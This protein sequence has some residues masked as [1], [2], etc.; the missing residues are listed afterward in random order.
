M[1]RGKASSLVAEGAIPRRSDFAQATAIAERLL[2]GRLGLKLAGLSLEPGGSR[3]GYATAIAQACEEGGLKLVLDI[4]GPDRFVDWRHR[5]YRK[6]LA[7]EPGVPAERWRSIILRNW[8]R[9]SEWTGESI[10]NW[11]AQWLPN[12]SVPIEGPGRATGH[13]GIGP[14]IVG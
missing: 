8:D 5:S 2:G 10:A 6:R 13:G 14:I 7:T 4:A 3:L 11:A 9:I 12:P 1:G